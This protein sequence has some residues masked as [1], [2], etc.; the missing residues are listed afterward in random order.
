MKKTLVILFIFAL[1]AAAVFAYVWENQ[2][3]GIMTIRELL[4]ENKDLKA[5]IANLTAEDQIGYATVADQNSSDGKLL[6]T[7]RFVETDRSDK[8]RH[9]LEKQYVLEGDVAHFDCL[10]VKF[11]NQKVTGG[12]EKALYLWR[13]VYGEKQAPADG[14]S[15]EDPNTEPARYK[16]LTDKLRL[17]DKKL[18]WESIWGLANEPEALADIGVTA[19]YGNAIYYRL[20]KGN[21]YIFKITSGGQVYPEVTPDF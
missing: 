3:Y 15:I 10:I 6:T 17:R 19:I 20:K 5:A 4:A 9:V 18:F 21:I 2:F 13:R 14:F 12:T 11:T 16:G 8:L 7:V 1:I